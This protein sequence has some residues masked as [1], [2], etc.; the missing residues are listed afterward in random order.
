MLWM[1]F[2]PFSTIS[3]LVRFPSAECL[4]DISL[5]LIFN[6][7]NHTIINNS[8]CKGVFMDKND[9]IKR[10]LIFQDAVETYP[11]KDKTYDEYAVLRHKTNGKWFGLVFYLNNRLCIN[12]KCN[13]VDSAILRDEYKFITPAW[14]M[15]KT[16]WILVDVNKSPKDLLDALIKES[17]EL[18][19]NKRK[20]Q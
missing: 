4:I 10:C 13:P 15:N 1:S 12:L 6:L 2:A 18:T 16:H 9:L 8:D 7:Y 3:H 11:F 19:A 14:H 17:F 5:D 20:S